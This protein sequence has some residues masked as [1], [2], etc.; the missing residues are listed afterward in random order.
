MRK[1]GGSGT[2]A[3]GPSKQ[4]VAGRATTRKRSPAKRK[5]P[6]RPP[7]GAKGPRPALPSLPNA[8]VAAA[9]L[10]QGE[11][12]RM[13]ERRVDRRVKAAEGARTQLSDQPRYLV[14]AAR[15]ILR[16]VARYARAPV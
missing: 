9:P 11:F 7:A 2:R 1:R 14:D 6:V 4:P 5:E 3:R 15:G 12:E 13:N 10:Q 16:R 8:P